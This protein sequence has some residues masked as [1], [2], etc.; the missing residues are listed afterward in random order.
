M[1]VEPIALSQP[2]DGAGASL[3][4]TNA[5]RDAAMNAAQVQYVNAH[6]T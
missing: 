6:A 4:M 5:L 2:E 1:N 3:A